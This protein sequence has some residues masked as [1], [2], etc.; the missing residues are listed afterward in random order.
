MK[1]LIEF[2]VSFLSTVGFGIITN[3]PRRALLPAGIAGSIS[4]ICYYL[5]IGNGTHIFLPNFVAAVVIG[6]LGNIGAVLR[7]VPVN[8]IYVP[9][10]VSLV[11]GAIIFL[12]MKN[13]TSGNTGI[14]QQEFLNTVL[15][16][17]A[18]AL[19]FLCSEAVAKPIRVKIQELNRS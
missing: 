8:T 17:L 19:G 9:S 1:L 10:L 3:V 18:L 2:I 16:A 11:P 15:I 6:V 5:L 7:K 13:F 4:W 12:G 14:A